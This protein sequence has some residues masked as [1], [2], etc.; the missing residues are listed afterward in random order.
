MLTGGN[1]VFWYLYESG[2]YDFDKPTLQVNPY[3]RL[4]L[5]SAET[6]SGYGNDGLYIISNDDS[7][8]TMGQNAVLNGYV[9]TPY[10]AVYVAPA[11]SSYAALNGCMAIESLILLNTADELPQGSIFDQIKKDWE[12]LV[13]G[14][15]VTEN[16]DSLVKQYENIVFN[17]VQPPLIT[18]SVLMGGLT[19][20]EVTDFNSVVW[21][22]LGYY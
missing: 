20:Q 9:Y 3:T 21:E 8:I 10:G 12:D 17:Y 18:D 19:D 14:G 13:G 15:N 1:M 2:S 7:L 16:V 6:G 22:F 4:G 5:V 11:E